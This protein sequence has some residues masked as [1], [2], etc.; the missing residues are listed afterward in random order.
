MDMVSVPV[1]TEC[2]IRNSRFISELFPCQDQGAARRLLKAQK[3]KYA[4]ATHVVHAFIIGPSGE[5]SGMSD[6]GEP[7][8]TA[9][10]PVLEVLRG[11]NCTNTLLTVTR[12][13]GGILLGTGGLVKA[14]SG[15]ARSVLVSADEKGAFEP[16]VM[17]TPFSFR[18][19][20]PLYDTVRRRIAVF[21]IY[22]LTEQ[23]GADVSLCGE[24]RS[25]ELDRFAACIFDLSGGKTVVE[26][27]KSL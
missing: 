21:H 13:F 24:I 16:V 27:R 26:P 11:R 7:P 8:G 3:Q 18:L 10:R 2:S 14:Y 20:Y 9:G 6:A 4:D 12:Y 15:C 1:C 23:F 17:K 22:G 19:P 5:I 25:D